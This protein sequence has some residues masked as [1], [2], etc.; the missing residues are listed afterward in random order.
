ME[1]ARLNCAQV[2][3]GSHIIRWGSHFDICMKQGRRFL[4]YSAP[5]SSLPQLSLISM[6][7]SENL[8][9]KMGVFA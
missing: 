1:T 9:L 7:Y 8:V 6:Q 5:E 2:T 4:I 3:F